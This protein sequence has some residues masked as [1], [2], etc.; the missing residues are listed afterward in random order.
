MAA[1]AGGVVRSARRRLD[2]VLLLDK[3]QGLTSNAVLQQVK[4]LYHAEKAGHTGTLDPLADGLLPICF[5]EATKFSVGLLDADKTYRATLRL[6]ITTETGD[7]EG[8]PLVERP[9]DVDRQRI[10]QVMVQ[11]RGDIMQVPHRYSALKRNGRALY[12]YA[13]AGETIAIAARAVHIFAI[14]VDSWERP[15]LS[16]SV[17]CSKGTY[18]RSLAEDIGAALGCGAHVVALRRTAVGQYGVE[19]A[20]SLAALES[21]S[22]D[23]RDA[24]LLPLTTLVSTFPKLAL[25]HERAAR[26]RQGQRIALDAGVWIADAPLAV[27]RSHSEAGAPAEFLGLGRVEFAQ[28]RW[29]LRASRLLATSSVNNADGTAEIGFSG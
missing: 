24:A 14:E 6:G 1:A 22:A 3:A 19:R 9:V 10:E 8:A 28:E 29:E 21:R 4:R 7:A 13:R 23:E 2:G 15:L 25:D 26:F 18:V 5:G 20:V 27:Y 11:F 12:D 16:M 17:K